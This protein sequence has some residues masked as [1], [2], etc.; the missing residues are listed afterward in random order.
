[1]RVV[2][3][4]LLILGVRA[5]H[6]IYVCRSR[7]GVSDGDTITTMIG[8]EISRIM[9]LH[10]PTNTTTTIQKLIGSPPTPIVHQSL[11]AVMVRLGRNWIVEW[12]VFYRRASTVDVWRLLHIEV[13]MDDN[14]DECIHNEEELHEWLTTYS[15]RNR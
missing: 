3:F 14:F 4:M 13:D 5:W 9:L 11:I 12:D 6:P 15:G 10:S 7:N 2:V 8:R 1:M